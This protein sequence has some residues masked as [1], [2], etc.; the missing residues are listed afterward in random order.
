MCHEISRESDEELYSKWRVEPVRL[1][2]Q[3]MPKHR[4]N[5]YSHRIADCTLCHQAAESEESGDILMPDIDDCRDCHGGENS[6]LATT[7]E[8]CHSL[9]LSGRGTMN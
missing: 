6:Q 5:H 2:L 4:F 1:T 8:G 7:C 3:W 9:H